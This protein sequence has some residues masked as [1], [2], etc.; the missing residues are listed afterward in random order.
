MLDISSHI[1]PFYSG[2]ILFY[3]FLIPFARS[4]MERDLV[5][6]FALNFCIDASSKSSAIFGPILL[7]H[8]T[9]WINHVFG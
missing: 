6:E 9:V 2:T 7:I 8:S 3:C 4:L 1:F 5:V